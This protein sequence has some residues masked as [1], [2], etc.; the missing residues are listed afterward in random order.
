MQSEQ[1]TQKVAHTLKLRLLTV[2]K[3]R[4]LGSDMVRITLEGSDLEGFY[5]PGFDDHVKLIF[6][7]P[8]TKELR[9]PQMGDRGMVFAAG[10]EK[11]PIR[12]YTPREFRE[13][14]LEMDID[15]VVHG[16]G[17][18]CQWAM[19]AKEGDK[20][21]VA[22]PRGSFLVSKDLDWQILIGDET[23]VPAMARRVKELPSNVKVQVYVLARNL[24]TVGAMEAP[25]HVTVNWIPSLAGLNGILD[26]LRA[27]PELSG[28]GYVWVAAEYSIA[29]SLREYWV[30]ERGLDKGAIRASSYWRQGDQ[31]EDAPRLD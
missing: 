18:A 1:L 30:Q 25:D 24:L 23:A 15:F 26:A 6:P 4:E 5:T 14:E 27:A 10:Q 17:P 22:G 13:Q 2:K 20:L 8:I 19:Q 3:R 9:L 11:P 12:D 28:T 21:G 7:D 29:Q 31:G 16:E